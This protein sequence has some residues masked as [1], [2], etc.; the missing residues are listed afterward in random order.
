MFSSF[1]W[2]GELLVHRQRMLAVFMCGFG[3]VFDGLNTAKEH[4]AVNDLF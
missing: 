2:G 3:G 1:F 4:P